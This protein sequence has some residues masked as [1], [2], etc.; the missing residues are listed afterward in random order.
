MNL[1]IP[2]SK[3]N[4]WIVMSKSDKISKADTRV[5]LMQT[6]QKI[7]HFEFVC[8]FCGSWISKKN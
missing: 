7:G 8:F 4:Y 2:Q 6:V 5:Q 1:N 3:M